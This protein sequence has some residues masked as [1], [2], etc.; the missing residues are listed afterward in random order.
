MKF[1]LFHTDKYSKARIGVIETDHGKIETPVFMPVGTQGTVKTQTPKDLEEIKAQI[2]L[3]NTYHLYL[4]PGANLIE[5][6]GG[7][8][9]FIK[10]DKPILTDSGGYQ[11]SSLRELR[12]IEPEGVRFKSHLDGSEH[13]FTP[14]KVLEIQ[15]KLGSD[16][17]MVLDECPPF[18]AKY[19]YIKRSNEVTLKW[20]QIARNVYEKR[21]K[22][23][24]YDQWLF[25]I[26]QGGIEKIIREISARELIK[27]DFPGY[28]IGGLAVGEKAED[29]YEI[30]DFCTDILPENKPRY[31]MGVGTPENLLMS[32]ERGVD[33]FDC[34]MPTRNARNGTVFSFNGKLVIKNSGFK[35][36]EKP[37]DFGCK[38]YVCQN[39]SRAY[40]RH[41]LHAG[42]I[43][44]LWLTTHHNL[45]FYIEL[46]EKARIEIKKN[47]YIDWKDKILKKLQNN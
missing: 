20:A 8:H 42:E 11:V 27:L 39:F 24:N 36:D 17:M 47:T 10:W 30:T 34:V 13:F 26:V 4:R 38:C 16:I 25:S 9:N 6:F 15:Q 7:L 28:A 18:P 14:E 19:E 44:G 29:M 40:I 21:K 46:M 37:I 3:A 1:H 23:Y 35:S 32:V 33:M 12:K 43:L 2:I 31:L 5:K 41:L 22:L 45:F